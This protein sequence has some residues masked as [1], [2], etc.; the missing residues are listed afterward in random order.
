MALQLPVLK[1][2][3][4]VLNLEKL[5]ILFDQRILRLCENVQHRIFA[6]R[7]ECGDHGSGR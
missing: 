6:E 2:Q 5:L 1:F 3:I 4:N 7:M